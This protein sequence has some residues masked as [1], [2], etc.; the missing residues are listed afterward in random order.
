MYHAT[1]MVT[2]VMHTS[3]SYCNLFAQ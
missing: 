3:E 2:A 1:E